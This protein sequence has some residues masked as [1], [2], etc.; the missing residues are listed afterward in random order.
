MPP[1]KS[2]CLLFFVLQETIKKIYAGLNSRPL[3]QAVASPSTPAPGRAADEA[4]NRTA[5]NQ[6]SKPFAKV[7]SRPLNQ[8]APRPGAAAAAG[9]V[10]VEE[11]QCRCSEDKSKH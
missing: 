10:V 1:P 5:S 9:D 11:A 2:F 6:I 4:R 7:N 8:A 3:N